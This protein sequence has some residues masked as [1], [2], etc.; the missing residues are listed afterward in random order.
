[1]NI[2]RMGS[3]WSCGKAR[4]S[5]ILIC[6]PGLEPGSTHP[7]HERLRDGAQLKAR[8]VTMEGAARSERLRQP[9]HLPFVRDALQRV[10]A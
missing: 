3:Q 6:H 5:T 9:K 10:R 7:P 2:R 4:S 8:G 1:M